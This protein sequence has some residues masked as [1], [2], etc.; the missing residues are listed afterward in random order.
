MTISQKQK[1][2][3]ED[4]NN[5]DSKIAESYSGA[6]TVLEQDYSEKI[7]QSA[8]SIRELIR[9]LSRVKEIKESG[10]L[11]KNAKQGDNHKER[12]ID[13][14]DPLGGTP[15]IMHYLYDDLIKV[16]YPWFQSVS[17][18]GRYPTESQYKKKLGEL[19]SL[20]KH[21]IKPHFEVIQDIDAILA[22][23]EPTKNNFKKLKPLLARNRSSYNHFF[24]KASGNWLSFLV[25][26]K[27]FD[28]PKH[29]IKDS[30][31]IKFPVWIPGKYLARISSEK[32]Q[33]VIKIIQSINLP[34]E[35]EERNPWI[36]DDLTN[37]AINM[38]TKYGKILV[39][40]IVK[41]NWIDIPYDALFGRTTAE[42]MVNLARDGYEKESLQLC[43]MLLDVKLGDPTYGGEY[44]LD[45]YKI[46]RDVKPILDHDDY[47]T[48][49]KSNVLSL[50][51]KFPLSVIE[52]LIESLNKVIFLDNVGRNEKESKDDTSVA[53]R[54]S[55]DDHEQNFDLDFKSLLAGTLGRFLVHEGYRSIPVLKK[56]ITLLGKKTYPIFR[57]LELHIYRKFPKQFKKEIERTIIQDFDNW[58]LIHEYFHLV[59]E[60]FPEMSKSVRQKYFELVEKEPEKE[61]LD[62]GKETEK[63]Q[64]KDY[65]EKRL[66]RWKANKLEPVSEY[67][68][69]KQKR[70]FDKLVKEVGHP[71][72]PDF[73][74]RSSGAKTSEPLTD[75]IDGLDTEQVFSF[76]RSYTPEEKIFGYHDGTASKFQEYVENQPAEFSRR[77]LD[78]QNT[79]PVFPRSLFRG[80]EEV[81]KK[82]DKKIEWSPVLSLCKY[83]IE[84]TKSN[85]YFKTRKFNILD[86]IADVLRLGLQ[87]NSIG[88]DLRKTVWELLE[89]LATFEDQSS[90]EERYPVE[91]WSSYGISINTVTGNTFHAIISYATW[92]HEHLKM[93]KKPVFVPEVKKILSSYFA[94]KIPNS[95]P[96]H[97]VLGFH[98]LNL[99]FFDKK[100]I[101]K[102]LSKM[103][104]HKQE[105]LNKAAWDAYLLNRVYQ[106]VFN[107]VYDNYY[108]HVKTFKNLQLKKEGGLWE[109][110]ERLIQHVTLAYLFGIQGSEKLF[111]K[112]LSY[113]NEKVLSYCAWFIGRILRKQKEN[114][115]KSFDIKV[116]RKIWKDSKLSANEEIDWWLEYTP[117]EKDESIKLVLNS[118]KKSDANLRLP[119]H[120]VDNLEPYAKSHPL[121]AVRCLELLIKKDTKDVEAHY[122]IGR[123]LKKILGILL[124]SKNKTAIKKTKSLIHYLGELNYNEYKELL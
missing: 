68:T 81:I 69:K 11:S 118:L 107:E 49:L 58:H 43:K 64:Q 123:D 21:I 85:K 110:D 74:F 57:R 120:L 121:Q 13:S 7:A 33:Q 20:L 124:K 15:E 100:W 10:V 102:N 83:I 95:I 82:N 112:M 117:F 52:F 55:I 18:H 76:I 60:N 91:Q 37:A 114:P 40:K 9:L 27:H 99:I 26:E 98:L 96:R 103:F 105:K 32:P 113:D 54:S 16:H 35:K 106:H 66:K 2:L 67:L 6:I 122:I 47:E 87:E 104:K 38:P 5:I 25:M 51:E 34:K 8:H 94:N 45:E 31:G 84:S 115:S 41:E 46:E 36:L 90:W 71:P 23:E 50:F 92:C 1:K 63:F 30:N 101:M 75:L 88:F 22:K 12:L 29:I 116:M 24:Q 19:E 108:K 44:I 89:L 62:F 56:A 61:L 109:F 97:A 65:A 79:N 80:L 53:W 14:L 78:L 17:H 77:S 3:L 4:L 111:N 70:Q 72:I 86:Y 59:K 28:N 39:S 119:F 48:I 73:H 93:N 42:F